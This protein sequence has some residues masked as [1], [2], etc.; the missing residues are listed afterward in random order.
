LKAIHE[1]KD[2]SHMQ[3]MNRNLQLLLQQWFS[4]GF[5][6]LKRVTWDSPASLLERVLAIFIIETSNV[7]DYRIFNKDS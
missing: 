3:V 6:S 5:L 1:E 2:R 4:I 7:A